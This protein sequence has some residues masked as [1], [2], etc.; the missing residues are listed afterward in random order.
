[1]R[2]RRRGRNAYAR[3][4]RVQPSDGMSRMEDAMTQKIV[5]V[6]DIILIAGTRVALGVGI[7]LLVS[8]RLREKT[9]E[10]AGWALLAIGAL[11]TIPLALKLRT[12]R[13]AGDMEHEAMGGRW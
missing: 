10:G 11:T 7:G 12:A 1:M 4:S 5:T 8:K 2:S 9:R 3:R 6:P 13:R